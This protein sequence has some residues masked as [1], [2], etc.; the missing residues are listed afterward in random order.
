MSPR[1]PGEL[2]W[3]VR[4]LRPFLAWYM[5]SF[6]CLAAGS[7]LSL[8]A[9]LALRWLIDSVLPHRNVS[10]L[11]LAVLLIFLGY[12]GRTSLLSLGTLLM[13]S[14]AQRMGLA[15]RM[16]VLRHLDSLSADYYDNTPV[17]AVMYPLKEPV[18]EIAN[19]GS[20]LL[21]SALRILFTTCF[22]LATM[23]VLSPALTIAVIPLIPAFVLIRQHFRQRLVASAE[24]V[25][26]DRLNWSA[27]LQEHLSAAVSIQL[28][29]QQRRQQRSAFRLLARTVRSQHR[30]YAA[31]TSYTI[32]G[33][34]VIVLAICAVI[35]YGGFCVV[36]GALTVGSL[37][38]FHGIAV[39]LFEPLSGAAELYA[40][41]QKALA[42]IRQ[43]RAALALQAT[44][45]EAEAPALLSPQ[46]VLQIDLEGVEFTYPQ[47]RTILRIP[48]LSILPGEKIALTGENGAG[49]STLAKLIA[50]LHDPI[51][52]CVRIGGQDLRSIELQSLRQHVSYVPRVPMLFDGTIASNLRL[53]KPNVSEDELLTATYQVGLD[54]FLAGLPHGLHQR[55]GPAG[56]QLSGGQGQRLAIARALLLKPSILILDEA[57]CCLDARSEMQILESIQARLNRSTI[58]VISHRAAT[59]SAFRRLLILSAGQIIGDGEPTALI[60]AGPRLHQRASWQ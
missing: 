10:L 9:P 6:V 25:Q 17:G 51:H 50:R 45:A 59:L 34:L 42:S 39:Q 7:L 60:A 4:R 18:D 47:Q 48:R 53:T 43:V 5:A 1:F 3:L 26:A 23:L 58:I 56:C 29:G 24:Q 22:T 40:R 41:T 35:A 8:L 19:F 12:Q 16:E 31:S 46:Q 55:V 44:V 14:S 13:L 32:W 52:G 28:L 27:F 15:L 30:L 38:A 36:A 2:Y 37:V 54:A 11:Y 57:T 49:K 21:P 33:S 20:D